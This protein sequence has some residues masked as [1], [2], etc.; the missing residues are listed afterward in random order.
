MDI[1]RNPRS[2]HLHAC[3]LPARHIVRSISRSREVRRTVLVPSKLL[4]PDRPLS[5]PTHVV[6]H[7]V[8]HYPVFSS[9]RAGSKASV[10]DAISFFPRI[11]IEDAAFVVLLPVL[12]VHRIIAGQFELT[13]AVVAVVTS[14]GGVDDEFLACF[15]VGEL[16]WAFVRGKTVVFPTSVGSLFPGILWYTVNG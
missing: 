2:I 1:I 3:I 13:E 10:A 14:S 11:L 5:P 16:L 6:P 4:R 12:W 15:G 8:V 9:V 7:T